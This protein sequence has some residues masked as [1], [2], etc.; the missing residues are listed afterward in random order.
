MSIY[1]LTQRN[2]IILSFHFF[3]GIIARA[4][5]RVTYKTQGKR[6]NNVRV[7]TSFRLSL[8]KITAAN[9]LIF[10]SDIEVW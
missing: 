3:V 10:E 6:H 1:L 7:C 9:C 8:Q 2:K 4:S 5:H